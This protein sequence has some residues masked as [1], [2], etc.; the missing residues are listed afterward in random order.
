[1]YEEQFHLLKIFQANDLDR[2]SV[3]IFN[4]IIFKEA[5]APA[6][7]VGNGRG[8]PLELKNVNR[9]ILSLKGRKTEDGVVWYPMKDKR[10]IY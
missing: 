7:E 1:M 6:W 8:L 4:W 10:N 5:I 9:G 2:D 3:T